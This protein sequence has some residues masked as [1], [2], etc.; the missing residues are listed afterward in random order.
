MRERYAPVTTS[1]GDVRQIEQI[2]DRFEAAWRAGE[3]PRLESYLTEATASLQGALLLELL[4]LDWEYRLRAGDPPQFPEYSARFPAVRSLIET[5]GREVA[6]VVSVG[7]QLPERLG[8]YRVLRR[9]GRG[10]MG[11]V[12]EAIDDSSGQRVALKLLP[13]LSMQDA[14]AR[15]RFRREALTTARLHHP[16]IVP[17][18]EVGEHD[19]Q[20]FLALEFVDG[21]TL[22]E[23]LRKAPQSPR[24]AATLVETLARAVHY[25]HEQG[26]VHRDLKPANVLLARMQAPQRDVPELAETTP[27]DLSAYTAR[28]T[29][30]GLAHPVGETELT[31]TGDIVGT[32]AYMAPEQAWGKSKRQAV[33]RVTDVYALGAVL[34]EALTGRPPF[35]AATTLETLEQVRSREPMPPARLQPGIPRDLETICLK[36]LAKEPLHRYATALEL[37]ED[38]RRFREGQPI[39]ARRTRLSR[40]CI[41]WCRSNPGLASTSVFGLVAL[42]A[43]SALAINHAV[44]RQLR[45]EQQLTRSALADAR[46]QRARAEANARELARQQALTQSALIDA[47]KFRRQAERLNASLCFERGLALVEQGDVACGLLLLGQGLEVASQGVADYEHVLRVNIAAAYA[48]LPYYLDSVQ[49]QPGEV[50]AVAFHPRGDRLLTGG[51]H[52]PPQQWDAVSGAPLDNPWSHR[53]D[54]HAVAY[55]PGGH[56]A[57]TGGSDGLVHLWNAATGEPAGEPLRHSDAVLSLA[58]GN[59]GATL[60]TGSRD[61]AVRIWRVPDGQLVRELA[62]SRA[63]YAVACSADGRRVAAAGA[64]RLAQIWDAATGQ[65]VGTPLRH[66]GEVWALAFRPD[67]RV[68]VAGSEEGGAWLWDAESGVALG[69]ALPH[70]GPIRAAGY[71]VDGQF[72]W[73]AGA[74]G[75]VRQWHTADARPA[76]APVQLHSAIHAVA[77]SLDQQRIATG[78]ADGGI[79]LWS[80]NETAVPAQPLCH[81]RLAYCLA[82]SPQGDRIVTGSADPHA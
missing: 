11:V 10:G 58:F 36:C 50:R 73:T 74:Y 26:V 67:G 9:L 65:A 51:R 27:P 33:G 82:I 12:Y 1:A 47:E 6:D 38:M 81:D 77:W 60:V 46:V 54:I 17:I 75:K 76:A 2:C 72:L 34:Y 4:P 44:T 8:R 7:G 3:R 55:S 68:L 25:A 61:G 40:R 48:R 42:L 23:L 64:N 80:R 35:Q 22:A 53:A 79:R 71:S 29:D 20:P 78:S 39:V 15:E 57:A 62:S 24:Q 5:I 52:S 43:A 32:P 37:A 30:F 70:Q 49:E 14:T 28:I 16:H 59:E 66:P 69:P 41:R 45:D 13:R 63:V 31:A 56:L 21:P 19:R 18:L